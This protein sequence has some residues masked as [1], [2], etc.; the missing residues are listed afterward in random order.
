MKIKYKKI[1]KRYRYYHDHAMRYVFEGASVKLRNKAQ[2]MLGPY[3]FS[4]TGKVGQS[5]WLNLDGKYI[6][7]Y[8]KKYCHYRLFLR[9]ESDIVM[10]I[11]GS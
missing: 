4:W 10:L 11:L 9:D 5:Y 1:D 7:D 8:D 3:N 6:V 2:E